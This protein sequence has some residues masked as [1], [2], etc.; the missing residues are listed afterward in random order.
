[1]L[2]S[3]MIVPV[4]GFGH[5]FRPHSPTT[6]G[7]RKMSAREMISFAMVAIGC[8]A[9]LKSPGKRPQLSGV[10]SV[11]CYVRNVYCVGRRRHVFIENISKTLQRYCRS[12]T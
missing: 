3:V 1:M 2:V 9:R 5:G 7:V 6:R 4:V 11:E 12:I 8:V 10:E